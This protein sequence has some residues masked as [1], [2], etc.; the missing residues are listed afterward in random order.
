M[1]ALLY[2]NKKITADLL[3]FADQVEKLDGV[4]FLD[5]EVWLAPDAELEIWGDCQRF[6]YP[7]P[8]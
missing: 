8:S 2:F 3:W 6:P 7:D 5:V 1:N 4:H